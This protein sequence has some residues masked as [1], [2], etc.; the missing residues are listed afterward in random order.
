MPSYLGS[1]SLRNKTIQGDFSEYYC[2]STNTSRGKRTMWVT[3]QWCIYHPV[4][5]KITWSFCPNKKLLSPDT[6]SFLFGL[7]GSNVPTSLTEC[8]HKSQM[9]LETFLNNNETLSNEWASLKDYL[10]R[11]GS[12]RPNL[13]YQVCVCVCVCVCVRAC[14]CVCV[15]VCGCVCVCVFVCLCVCACARA[16]ACACARRERE[17]V[18]AL[19]AGGSQNKWRIIFR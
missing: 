14:V 11:L 1:S 4:G 8:C 10:Q 13:L 19:R 12:R 17:R 9:L 7:Y 18:C 2:I 6:P 3:G 15:W 5:L 16:C